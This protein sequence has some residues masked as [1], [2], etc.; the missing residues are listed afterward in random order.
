MHEYLAFADRHWIL[1]VA[2]G[3]VL[4]LLVADEARRRL[5]TVR[6][7]LPTAAVQM[8]NRGAV[9][10][11]CRAAEDFRGGHI[12]GASNVPL[13]ELSERAGEFAHKRA[14]SVLVVAANQRETT[15]AAGIL[16]RGGVEA[17]VII[18]GGLAAWSKDNLPLE[19]TA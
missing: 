15:R 6:E 19:R 13:G 17:V 9:V 12:V 11:D 18:K 5:S 2:L 4:A 14:K 3:V 8:I 7:I 10:V 1:V 16:R